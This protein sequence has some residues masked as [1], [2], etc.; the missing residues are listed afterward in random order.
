[1]DS[2]LTD[3]NAQ[4]DE[5][6]ETVAQVPFDEEEGG[7][8]W[9]V[10]GVPIVRS[11]TPRPLSFGLL[12]PTTTSVP[13]SPRSSEQ[14]GKATFP[15]EAPSAPPLP[16]ES[17]M[18]N[19]ESELPDVIGATPLPFS[20]KAVPLEDTSAEFI[21]LFEYAV[22]MDIDFL[23]SPERL[24]GFAL[25]YGPAV[26]KGYEL[27]FDVI[28]ARSGGVVATILPSRQHGAEVWGVLYRVPR[29]FAERSEE[30]LSLI[31]AVHSA[32][33]PNGLFERLQVVVYEAYRSRDILCITYIASATARNHYHL[34]PRNKQVPEPSYVERLLASARKQKLPGGYLDELAELVSL[35]S[36]D[37]EEE[38][39]HVS[40]QETSIPPT[41]PT[42]PERNTEPL[43]TVGN[44]TKA[45]FPLTAA[46]EVV[47]RST[48]TVGLV[49]Y[50]VYLL[51]VVL[52]V[53]ALAIL[54]GLGFGSA[55]LTT[56]FTPLG[57]PWFMLIYGLLGGCLSCMIALGRRQ[58]ITVPDFV[59]ITW[60]S[61]PL[62]GSLLA[63]LAYLLLNSGILVFGGTVA[64]HAMLYSLVAVLTG[65]SEGW[66]FT[67]KL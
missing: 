41:P 29:R 43:P 14:V 35:P 48:N 31:D 12:K 27:T 7:E 2:E 15:V 23:N 17:L 53:F 60:F 25:L 37:D 16:E 32:T 45:Q 28:N 46:Q 42:P 66:L 4:A 30:E 49:I 38:T 61:R 1:M 20:G 9:V 65:A 59:L 51:L 3:Y 63:A 5:V 33:P 11:S 36:A 34:L 57:I 62:M 22:E 64:Q 26:L 50:A 44:D 56:S 58:A 54:Q 47:S 40:T 67:R 24:D 6:D 55:Y 10:P 8:E 13:Q 21:W 19:N 18:T 52:A 39:R